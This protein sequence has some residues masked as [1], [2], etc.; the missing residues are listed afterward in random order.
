M[1]PFQTLQRGVRKGL[2]TLFILSKVIVPVYMIVTFIKHTVLI[3]WIALVFS[4][5]MGV[6][7]LPGEAAIILVLGNVL[8]IY[9]AI[10]AIASIS[11]TM[12][13]I[14]ILAVMI[15]F[16]HS[17]LVETAVSKRIGV[18]VPLILGVRMGMAAVAGIVVN[19]VWM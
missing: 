12:K 2:E 18:S 1:K 9:A 8:N 13:Q 15:S 4:P 10:G 7:G 6:F 3:E 11:L 16:S 5:L 14:T 17:L 19:I